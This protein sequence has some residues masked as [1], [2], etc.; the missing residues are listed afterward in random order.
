MGDPQARSRL[1]LAPGEEIR[2]WSFTQVLD[3]AFW[4]EEDGEAS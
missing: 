1:A 3:E 4:P 2:P